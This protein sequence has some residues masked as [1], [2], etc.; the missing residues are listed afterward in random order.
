MFHWN[1]FCLRCSGK[2]YCQ[3]GGYKESVS[4]HPLPRSNDQL[5][6]MPVV[7]QMAHSK[8]GHLTSHWPRPWSHLGD[9]LSAVG[10][11]AFTLISLLI[12]DLGLNWHELTTRRA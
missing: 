7:R 2:R 5:Y 1:S 10:V 11:I 9:T 6:E 8:N 12:V 4:L 3:E